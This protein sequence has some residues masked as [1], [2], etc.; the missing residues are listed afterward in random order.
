MKIKAYLDRKGITT[1]ELK[2]TPR[3]ITNYLRTHD[4]DPVYEPYKTKPDSDP[5]TAGETK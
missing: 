2:T 3:Y 5:A 1:P 4:R